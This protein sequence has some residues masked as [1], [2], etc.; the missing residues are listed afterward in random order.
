MES[1]RKIQPDSLGNK[2]VLGPDGN[3][4]P[5]KET[6]MGHLHDA[7]QWWNAEGRKHGAKSPEIRK[8]MLDPDNYELE[9]SSIN[10]SRGGKLKERYLPPLK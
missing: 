1:E 10:R 8:W 6:D 3:W 4:Y 7:V 2:Q 5:V 9:P